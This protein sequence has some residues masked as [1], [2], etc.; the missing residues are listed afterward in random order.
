MSPFS[1]RQFQTALADRLPMDNSGDRR[2]RQ[3]AGVFGSFTQPTPVAAPILLGWS[4]SLAKQFAFARPTQLDAEILSGNALAPGMK[5]Y[6]VCYGGHQFGHW[7]GQLGDGRA[8]SLGET[9]D[10]QGRS[11]EF[12]LKGAGP[13]PYSRRADGRAVL[14]SSV[15]EFICSEAMAALGVPTT[16]ALSLCLTGEWVVRDPF[17]D[18]HPQE[19][20]GAIVCRVSP[21]FLRFG[22][23]EIF[24]S[25]GET[26]LLKALLTTCLDTHFAEL[27]GPLED[28]VLPWFQ[29]VSERTAFLMAEWLRV[30]F[31]HG[32]MNTDNMSVLGLTIDYGPYGWLEPY[33]PSW[34]PNTTDLPG[35]RYAFGR[36]PSIGL[37][38]LARLGDAI[39]SAFPQHQQGFEDI[40]GDYQGTFQKF[41][42]KNLSQK[43]GLRELDF[44]KESSFV[45]SL[46]EVM[47][48]NQVDFTRFFRGLSSFD[49]GASPEVFQ[50][51]VRENSYR[52]VGSA[53]QDKTAI[54]FK[55]YQH[56]LFSEQILP[57][58]RASIMNSVN[59]LYVP[60]NFLLQE[61]IEAA[62]SGDVN[63]LNELLGV[64][65]NPYEEQTGREHQSSLRPEW[66]I[67]KPGC[68]TLS[69]SS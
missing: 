39:L 9:Q 61:V 56:R 23:F 5:P 45:S 68:S 59:P 53:E 17:Y 52:S 58:D 48:Q 7:A 2:S 27:Q 33:D 8:I 10:L 28:R 41:Y 37:W 46:E 24:A 54:W 14:R 13:T 16:R 25:R 49:P 44:A 43:L 35:R 11:W 3:V 51:F 38:N 50:R 57:V 1:S 20:P 15:R 36:Q 65:S 18:G 47:Q 30:G 19:E 12:Q 29:I 32:V 22:N 34:T 69:C 67:N 31:V 40:L 21:S 6:A 55:E 60:R 42:F 26:E 66:A 4:A 63:P 62:S 64:L